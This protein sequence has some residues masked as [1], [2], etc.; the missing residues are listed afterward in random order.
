M[1]KKL[2]SVLMAAVVFMSCLAPMA[3]AQ[4]TVVEKQLPISVKQMN[5]ATG[6]WTFNNSSGLVFMSKGAADETSTVTIPVHIPRSTAQFGTKLKSVKVPIRVATADLDAAATADIHRIDMDAVVSG[7]TGDAAAVAITET[8]NGVVTADANDRLFTVTI[9]SPDWDY[10]TEA[11][12][13]YVVTLTLNAATTSAIRVYDA[14][15]VYDE[16]Q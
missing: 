3:N 14:Y 1:Y 15:A 7:A 2:M 12:A 9:T 8:D 6:T 13:T 10:S 5:F 4:H 16:L 11:T